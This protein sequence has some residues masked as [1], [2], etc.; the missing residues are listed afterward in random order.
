M[1]VGRI[2]ISII[3]CVTWD[4]ALGSVCRLVCVVS[5]SLNK[6]V[7][8]QNR[9]E[10]KKSVLIRRKMVKLK[11][12]LPRRGLMFY[13]LSVVH[14]S[15]SVSRIIELSGEPVIWWKLRV[16]LG[17]CYSQYHAFSKAVSLPLFK[18][19]VKLLFRPPVVPLSWAKQIVFVK[20][21]VSINWD[22]PLAGLPPSGKIRENF[23]LLE[24]QGISIF[25]VQ[26]QG[27]SGICVVRSGKVREKCTKKVRESQG[28]Q[29]KLTGGNPDL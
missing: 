23:D 2:G 1:P 19:G 7:T 17:I 4:N 28:I 21:P 10:G 27:K 5:L 26:S 18:E 29:I 12:T 16:P 20:H 14:L 3:D 24:S 11:K 25:F 8:K 15:G 6:L 22:G 9:T 13:P